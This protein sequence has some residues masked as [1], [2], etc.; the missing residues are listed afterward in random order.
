[1]R[2]NTVCRKTLRMFFLLLYNRLTISMGRLI[3]L[4]GIWFTTIGIIERCIERLWG[5]S[6]NGTGNLDG[7]P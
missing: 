7:L 3:V 6:R 5:V 4:Q 2:R 1:M